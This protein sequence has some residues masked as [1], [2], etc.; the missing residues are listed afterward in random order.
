MKKEEQPDI[1]ELNRK[2]DLMATNCECPQC[3]NR[4]LFGVPYAQVPCKKC[5]ITFKTDFGQDI[6]TKKARQLLSKLAFKN[7]VL[8]RADE[9]FE[10]SLIHVRQHFVEMACWDVAEITKVENEKRWCRA[11]GICMNCYTCK[12]CGKAFQHDPNRRKQVCPDCRVSNFVKTYFK[13]VKVM[14]EN[15]DIRLCPHCNS[16]NIRMTRTKNKTKCHV[17]NSKKLT[18][19]K[20]SIEYSFTVSRKKAYRRE[21][22]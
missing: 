6:Y 8:I 18:D 13:N 9:K 15:K 11:C 16:D 2:S 3:G 21:N 12:K 7:S 22:I 19:I 20:V 14:E 1:L 4:Y 17:C 5:G 10:G